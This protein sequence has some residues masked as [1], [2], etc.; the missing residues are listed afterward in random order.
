MEYVECPKCNNKLEI[1]KNNKKSSE[2]NRSYFREY[3]FCNSCKYIK[4]DQKNRVFE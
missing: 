2:K 1:R 4:T 3:L